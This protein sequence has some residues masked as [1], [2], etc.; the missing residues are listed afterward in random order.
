[1]KSYAFIAY[2][3]ACRVGAPDKIDSLATLAHLF[4]AHF[5]RPKR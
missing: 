4:E 5:V 2:H 1:M 3:D